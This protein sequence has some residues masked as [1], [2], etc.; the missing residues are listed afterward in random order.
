MSTIPA[1][2]DSSYSLT[3]ELPGADFED[4]V[5][6]VRAA[7]SDEGFG[8]LTEINVQA[9]LNKKLGVQTRPYLIL[10]AC[11]PPLAHQALQAEPAI[12][13]LLPCNVVVAGAEDGVTVA[14]IDPIAMFSIVGR[15]DVAPLANEVKARLERVLAAL[16]TK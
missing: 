10:G 12:G 1:L 6:R 2:A 13:V 15:E 11:N 7:L 3:V 5:A 14:A 9:T 4:A 16:T 8:V